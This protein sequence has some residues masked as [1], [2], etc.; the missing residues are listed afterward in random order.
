MCVR[1][2]EQELLDISWRAFTATQA[3]AL[4]TLR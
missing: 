2:Q 4:L 1:A 3:K